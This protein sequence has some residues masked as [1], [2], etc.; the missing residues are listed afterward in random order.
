MRRV[1]YFVCAIC[2]HLESA[3]VGMDDF[4]IC[5]NLKDFESLFPGISHRCII[6]GDGAIAKSGKTY[7]SSHGVC[8]DHLEYFEKV[9]GERS[10]DE[11]VDSRSGE[12]R[13]D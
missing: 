7:N 13:Q 11:R 10:N 9:F 3:C 8:H 4:T 2:N 12:D 1:R 6:C 5:R